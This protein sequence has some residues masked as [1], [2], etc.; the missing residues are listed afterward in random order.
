MLAQQRESQGVEP[1]DNPSMAEWGDPF[2]D[3]NNSSA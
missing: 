3:C 2:N 1:C